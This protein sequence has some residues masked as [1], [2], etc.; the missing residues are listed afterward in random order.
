MRTKQH[1]RLDLVKRLLR[2]SALLWLCEG[3]GTF[4][5]VTPLRDRM[6]EPRAPESVEVFASGPPQRPHVDIAL[7][8]V[9]QTES[10]NSQGTHL[11]LRR[12]REAAGK[13]GCDAVVI[14]GKSEH[15]GDDDHIFDPSSHS[16]LASCLVYEVTG[17][18]LAPVTAVAPGRSGLD[19]SPP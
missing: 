8:E 10:W 14:T 9:E 6:R 13:L 15:S 16:L 7:L 4:V 18:P 2:A 17:T 3:C 11:M 1:P 19:Q 5:T 12:L